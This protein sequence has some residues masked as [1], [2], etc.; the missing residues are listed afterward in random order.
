ME[1]T[2]SNIK[3]TDR[4]STAGN[5]IRDKELTTKKISPSVD[6]SSETAPLVLPSQK[7]EKKKSA[8]PSPIPV[9]K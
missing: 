7:T 3:N 5:V 4:T 6:V 1:F 8:T 9:S 2:Y